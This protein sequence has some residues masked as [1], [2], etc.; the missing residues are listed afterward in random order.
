VK[1]VFARGEIVP[2]TSP[3]ITVRSFWWSLGNQMKT[4]TS[5]CWNAR[6]LYTQIHIYLDL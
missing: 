3:D 1:T 4:Q 5:A 6:Y 2:L